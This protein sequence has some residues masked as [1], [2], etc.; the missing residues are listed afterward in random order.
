MFLLPQPL[1]NVS[2]GG[3]EAALT[4]GMGSSE[5]ALQQG[6]L[7]MASERFSANLYLFGAMGD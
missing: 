3:P 2:P 4:S 7:Q 6:E 1:K 5:P